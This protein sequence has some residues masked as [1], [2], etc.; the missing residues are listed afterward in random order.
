MSLFK[1]IAVAIA[2]AMDA[3]AVAVAAGINIPDLNN[4]HR[5]RLSWHF[6]LFQALMPVLGWY[7]GS[8]VRTLVENYDHW[9]AFVLLISV[10]IHMFGEAFQQSKKSKPTKDPTRGLK[11]ITLSIATSID[12]LAVGFSFSLLKIDIT[13]PAVIIGII[14]GLFTFTGIQLGNQIGLKTKAGRYA[15]L[16]G[17]SIL[18]LISLNIL[19]SH[20]ALNYIINLI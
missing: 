7:S 6:G 15:H 8:S 11:L 1:I 5:F 19:K 16:V 14:A 9:I 20:G 12:A 17:G 4:R 13:F 18:V 3:F 10:S 2:L